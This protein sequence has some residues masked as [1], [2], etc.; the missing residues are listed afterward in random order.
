[1]ISRIP[2]Y[3][4]FILLLCAVIASVVIFL[5][6]LT[7]VILAAAG[8]ILSFPIYRRI[9]A[10]LGNGPWKPNIAA[11]LT[12]CIIVIIVL[13]PLFLIVGRIYVEIQSMY[14]SLIDESQR[15][16]IIDALNGLSSSIS[17]LLF[18]AFPSYTFDSLNVTEY[19]KGAIE[20]VFSHL[21]SI[22]TSF[23]TVAINSFVFLLAVFYF[24]RDGETIK[25]QFMSWSPLVDKHDEHLTK[26][27]ENAIRSVFAGTVIVCVIQGI[28]TGI[29]FFMFGIPAAALWGS[30]AA[31]AAFIPGFGTS[32]IIVPG[33]IYLAI[34][35]GY[36]YAI[37]LTIWGFLAVS[38]IDNLL[39][40]YLVNRG[41]NIHPLL[42]LISV[43]GGIATF[44]PVGFVMGPI[45]LAILFA[46]LDIY[47]HSFS[48]KSVNTEIIQVK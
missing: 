17:A 28:L 35:S 2:Y 40:P 46:L 32:L 30:I 23:A 26:T 27:F 48:D 29:G 11:F 7:P 41:I 42:I 43:L 8:A 6:F 44:G 45:I 36:G 1:M 3:F 18:D 19:L 38:L 13:V 21:D 47:R 33:I 20:W 25:K 37:G 39:G 10:A 9:L 16:Q 4:F 14:A 31:V 34:F 24:L 5:P 12:V 22:F 15:S